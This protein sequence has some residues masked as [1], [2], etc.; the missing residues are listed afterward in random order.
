MV[1]VSV[2][3]AAAVVVVVSVAAA[4]AAVAVKVEV[5]VA[6]DVRVVFVAVV[7]IVFY[8]ID[9]IGADMVTF[10]NTCVV[11]IYP[12]PSKGL[13]TRLTDLL[14]LKT[15]LASQLCSGL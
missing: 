3:A 12:A 5:V 14:E 4:A 8:V 13:F 15:C 9:F 1:V 10:R 6:T 2:A 11:E 7:Y